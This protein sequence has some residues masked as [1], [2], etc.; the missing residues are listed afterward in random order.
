MGGRYFGTSFS[1]KRSRVPPAVAAAVAAPSAAMQRHCAAQ[2][3]LNE[4]MI[5]VGGGL[6]HPH[7]TFPRGSFWTVFLFWAELQTSASCLRTLHSTITLTL[8]TPVKR[9]TY[10]SSGQPS[11]S[12]SARP[13]E[14][15]S[16]GRLCKQPSCS[17]AAMS[18]AGSNGGA[19]SPL[20]RRMSR[21]LSIDRLSGKTLRVTFVSG[22]GAEGV[23]GSS[24]RLGE[25]AC[26]CVLAA[27]AQHSRW[28]RFSHPGSCAA[29][30]VGSSRHPSRRPN[31][32]ATR[33]RGGARCCRTC[34]RRP[35]SPAQSWRCCC[36]TSR[37][38]GAGAGVSLVLAWGQPWSSDL[39]VVSCAGLLLA[40]SCTD[41]P[42]AFLSMPATRSRASAA[43]V[44]RAAGAPDDARHRPHQQRDILQVTQRG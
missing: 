37:W 21:T 38:G 1:C 20:A 42:G 12:R 4:V 18:S 6:L 16:A 15:N 23:E 2:S 44:L 22:D 41:W 33:R 31:Q 39:L 13:T 36:T 32:Q 30:D 35:T 3:K 7:L 14:I 28:R 34:R 24:P 17:Q 43:R 5:G 9:I 25:C 29:L 10:S 8:H 27:S 11:L 19:T 26:G 40:R